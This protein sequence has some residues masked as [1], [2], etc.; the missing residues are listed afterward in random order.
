MVSNSEIVFW[1]WGR[2]TGGVNCGPDEYP[3]GIPSNVME[4]N[5]VEATIG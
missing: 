2:D 5:R 3:C 4:L 1:L